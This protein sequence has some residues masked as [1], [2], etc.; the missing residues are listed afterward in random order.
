[1]IEISD[2]IV[3]DLIDIAQNNYMVDGSY[4]PEG[5]TLMT[6]VTLLISLRLRE[7]KLIQMMCEI[8]ESVSKAREII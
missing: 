8:E 4:L 7:D 3:Q 1:M 5:R 6:A 2:T